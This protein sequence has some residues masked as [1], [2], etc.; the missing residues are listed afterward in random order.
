MN[1][2]IAD[3]I[4][5]QHADAVRAD[6]SAARR[7]A[8]ARKSRTARTARPAASANADSGAPSPSTSRRGA[9]VAHVVA[10]PFSAAH[11]WLAAGEL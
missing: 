10:R 9:A 8:R 11:S 3:S 4:A 1:V 6:A 2:Y 5:R 7:L